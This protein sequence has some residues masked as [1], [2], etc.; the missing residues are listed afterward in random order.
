MKNYFRALSDA[1]DG[2]YIINGSRD[3][4]LKSKAQFKSKIL[5]KRIDLNIPDLIE[6]NGKITFLQ[7]FRERNSYN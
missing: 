7:H 5:Q 2:L 6:P 4:N 3:I 1:L